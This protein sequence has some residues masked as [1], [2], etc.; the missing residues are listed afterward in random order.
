MRRLFPKDQRGETIIE[1]AMV[2]P[3]LLL[4]LFGITEFGRAIM[5]SNILSTASREGAR[6]FIRYP[7]P[8]PS[9]T[10]S[11][12]DTVLVAARLKLAKRSITIDSTSVTDCVKVT[13]AYNF[14]VLSGKILDFL[15]PRTWV[16][17]GTTVMR[18]E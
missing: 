5:V 10:I 13:I 15:G 12:I 2:L 6:L 18:R 14:E 1:F 7:S 8:G 11:R 3:I 9:E 4:V 16:L 17:K